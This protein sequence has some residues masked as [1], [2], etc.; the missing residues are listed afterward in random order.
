MPAEYTI[1]AVIFGQYSHDIF[2]PFR[3]ILN[4]LEDKTGFSSE[5]QANESDVRR[6]E[7]QS[8]K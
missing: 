6:H 3:S 1:T 4:L 8:S 2:T 7:F 5:E